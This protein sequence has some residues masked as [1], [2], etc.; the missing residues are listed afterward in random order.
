MLRAADPLTS[1]ATGE[2]ASELHARSLPLEGTAGAEYVA[3]RAIPVELASAH[4]VRFAPDLCGRPAVVAP[5]RG[6][7]GELVAL[8]GRHLHA[9]HAQDKMTTIGAQGGVFEALDGRRAQPLIVVE[10]LFDALSLAACGF[11]CLATIGR[12]VDWL[13]DCARERDVWIA[14]DAAKAAER[15]AQR[16]IRALTASRCMRVP[17]PPRCQDWN[18]ALRKLGAREVER[19]LRARLELGDKRHA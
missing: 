8:H 11:A 14:F 19:W 1:P 6:E 2:T 9:D 7:C 5:L 4:G 3:R 10:G 18:N 16:L 12:D 13:P 17:P 15:E